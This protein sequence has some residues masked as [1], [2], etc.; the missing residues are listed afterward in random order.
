MNFRQGRTTSR[1]A[2]NWVS[3]AIDSR[4]LRRRLMAALRSAYRVLGMRRRRGMGL[5]T[6]GVGGALA[7]ALGAIGVVAFPQ[8][9]SADYA[10]GG[11][12]A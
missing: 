3:G 2:G 1:F 4:A 6:L 5:G 7:V 12:T 11:G 10:A 9:A 8:S